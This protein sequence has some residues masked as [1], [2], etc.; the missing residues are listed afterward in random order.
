MQLAH[1]DCSERP[2]GWSGPPHE[3]SAQGA[4]TPVDG[5]H[6][7]LAGQGSGAAA[8]GAQTVPAGPGKHAACA[9][10]GW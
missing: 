1:C 2:V 9:A 10:C 6:T 8:P 5:P 4:G 3:P 7:W